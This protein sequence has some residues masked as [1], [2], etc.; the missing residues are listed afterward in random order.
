M[1]PA[2]VVQTLG[3]DH[4]GF[5]LTHFD[6]DSTTV[7]RHNGE[8]VFTALPAKAEFLNHSLTDR[9]YEHKFAGEHACILN[10]GETQEEFFITKDGVNPLHIILIAGCG[11][12]IDGI[13]KSEIGKVIYSEPRSSTA[14]AG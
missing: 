12:L 6:S 1:V 13:S 7:G 11:H 8:C 3:G 9:M 5:I 4:I 2:L 10:I 14:L